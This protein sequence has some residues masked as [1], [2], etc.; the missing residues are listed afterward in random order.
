MKTE[1]AY[2][3]WVAWK[4][5]KEFIYATEATLDEVIRLR[6]NLLSRKPEN[7]TRIDRVTTT[8]EDVE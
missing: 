5:R 6:Q 7:L 4:G 2:R 8:I 1:I 3:L